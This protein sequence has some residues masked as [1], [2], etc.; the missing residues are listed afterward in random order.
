M[1]PAAATAAS[2]SGEAAQDVS[3]AAALST[4]YTLDQV[5][6]P[7]HPNTP[8]VVGSQDYE[9]ASAVIPIS[10]GSRARQKRPPSFERKSRDSDA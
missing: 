5:I 10:S 6:E 9:K 1:S 8:F 3:E 4:R 7:A 2:A